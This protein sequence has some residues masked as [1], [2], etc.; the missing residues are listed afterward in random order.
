M[1]PE[2]QIAGGLWVARCD[3]GSGG[4]GASTLPSHSPLERFKLVPGPGE[5]RKRI[6]P[7]WTSTS[8]WFL[9]RPRKGREWALAA[10]LLA[11]GGNAAVQWC[12]AFFFFFGLNPASPPKTSRLCVRCMRCSYPMAW[13]LR[14]PPGD[15]STVRHKRPEQSHFWKTLLREAPLQTYTFKS[16]NNIHTTN[17][18]LLNLLENLA[19][20]LK[21]W[22]QCFI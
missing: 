10:Y 12:Q 9:K 20:E 13:P 14:S 16:L 2:Q 18:L 8:W 22:P 5:H 21:I 11:V 3:E 17:V 4:D 15:R 7:T 19:S 1:S 6:S